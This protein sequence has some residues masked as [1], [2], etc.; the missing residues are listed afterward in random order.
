MNLSKNFIPLC[1]IL[2]SSF[3]HG[4]AQLWSCVWLIATPWTLALQDPLSTGFTRQEYWS[5]LSFPSP[6]DLPNTGIKPTC[7][8]LAAGF[9][10][11]E[12]PGKD[13]SFFYH[14]MKNLLF[15]T[16]HFYIILALNFTSPELVITFILF[17]FQHNIYLFIYV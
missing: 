17:F 15:C 7:P 12:P 8:T 5:G 9:S 4:R 13:P 6:G 1:V 11:S 3:F 2:I 16:L 14:F 10:T